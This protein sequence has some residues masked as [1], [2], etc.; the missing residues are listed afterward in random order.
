MSTPLKR[1]VFGPE[2]LLSSGTIT[3]ARQRLEILGRS[4]AILSIND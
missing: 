1:K 2:G 3:E 4:G